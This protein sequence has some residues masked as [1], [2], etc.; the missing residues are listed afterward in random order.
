MNNDFINCFNAEWIKKRRS[1]ASWLVIIGG[2]FA[3]FLQILIFSFY[4]KQLMAIHAS[5]HFWELLFQKSWQFLAFMLLPM[6]IVLAVSLITQ[7]EF[8][9]NSWKQL[10]TT[11]VSFSTIYFSKLAVLTVMLLQLLFLFNL[12]VI[13]SAVIPSFFNKQIPFPGYAIN[14]WYFLRES[15]HYF[16]ICLPM[17]A[18][19]YLFSLQFKNF[20]IPVGIG[21][22]LVVGGLIAVSW[23]YIYMMPSVKDHVQPQYNILTWSLGYFIVFTFIGYILYIFKKEKG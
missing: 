6:G 20:L 9:N 14:G 17:I 3:A 23:K 8:K 16:I 12:G 11:P 13:L 4:P 10:H 19:Q 7:I 21:L 22:A 5:G 18:L 2:F 1:F 15:T